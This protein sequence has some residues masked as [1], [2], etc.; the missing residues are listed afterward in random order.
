MAE[1]G[2]RFPQE[3]GSAA[4]RVLFEKNGPAQHCNP[5]GHH[6]PVHPELPIISSWP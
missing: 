4:I 2:S 6:V 5:D 1:R 3:N